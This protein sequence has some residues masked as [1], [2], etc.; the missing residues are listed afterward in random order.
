MAHKAGGAN[1]AG[2][3]TMELKCWK[4]EGK[5]PPLHVF[6]PEKTGKVNHVAVVVGPHTAEAISWIIAMAEGVRVVV[7]SAASLLQVGGDLPS[8][9]GWLLSEEGAEDGV[10]IVLVRPT[11]WFVSED[12]RKSDLPGLLRQVVDRC[13]DPWLMQ[14]LVYQD[15]QYGD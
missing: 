7:L 1:F 3:P 4:V 2:D 12:S 13:G 5:A 11:E 8:L 10:V 14:R 6:Q 15:H 9:R